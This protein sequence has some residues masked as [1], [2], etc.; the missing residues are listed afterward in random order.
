M[1][2]SAL[3]IRAESPDDGRRPASGPCRVCGARDLV[4]LLPERLVPLYC[5]VLWDDR[6]AAAGAPRGLLRLTLCRDCGH[7][8]NEAFDPGLLDYTPAYENSLHFSGHFSRY[9]EDLARHLVQAHGV[10][11]K[12]VVDVGCGR[13][14]FLA[15]L[16][17]LGEN[18]G[19]GFDRS[20]P[21]DSAELS[22]GIDLRFVPEFFSPAQRLDAIDLLCCRQVLEHI[23]EPVGFIEEILGSASVTPDTVLFF[24]VP[25]A[26][27]TFE[28]DGIW[29]LIYEHCSY[30]SAGSLAAL[31]ER[32][33]VEVL[34]SSDLYSGQYL[35]IEA[36]RRRK[37]AGLRARTRPRLQ[38]RPFAGRYEAKVAFWRDRTARWAA[39]GE[40]V[41]IWGAGSKGVTF[42]D[43]L[44]PTAIEFAVDLNPRKQGKYLPGSAAE[45][46]SP[47]FLKAYRPERVIM[48]NAVYREEIAATLAGFG[49]SPALVAA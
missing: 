6:A 30:F 46:V 13:G 44:G 26:R 36:R 9:A 41:V 11:G 2:E 43:T 42:L 19:I 28:D 47:E 48:M 3:P 37:T 5:N 38:A 32:C 22:R 25:N 35:G 7:V 18:R 1:R 14:D 12:L 15:L 24:E 39:A 20:C 21:P 34:A 23:S 10:R 17:R 31:F 4:A 33:G 8:F 49:L 40:R 29:D 45:V 16:C 27:Y